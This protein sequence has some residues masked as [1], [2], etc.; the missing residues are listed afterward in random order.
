MAAARKMLVKRKLIHQGE[1][2]PEED[3]PFDSDDSIKD[4]DYINSSESDTSGSSTENNNVS[5]HLCG[6]FLSY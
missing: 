6:L 1:E 3:N 5:K 4:K 2:S